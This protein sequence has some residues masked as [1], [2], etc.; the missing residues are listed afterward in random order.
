VV[1]VGAGT[2]KLTRLLPAT[3]ARVVA[4]EPL[5]EMRALIEGV[6]AVAGTAEELPFADGFADVIVAAQAFHWFDHERALP[7]LHRVLVPEGSLGL[8]WN[9]RDLSDP[10]QRAVEELLEPYRVDA[11]AQSEGEW[12]EPLEESPLF[13][14]V[15][16]RRFPHVLA[17]TGDDLCARVGST[18]FVAALPPAER[19]ALIARTRA[20]TVGLDEPFP[21]VYRTDVYAIPRSRDQAAEG[22]GTSIQG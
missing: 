3:G 8:I 7:E 20:L 16:R 17:Y 13:G 4:V 9:S 21:F 19:D 1:D 10:L 18:S 12:V 2:G 15:E 22:G 11:V 14:P 6:E 5:P